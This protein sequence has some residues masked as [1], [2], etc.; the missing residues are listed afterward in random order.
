M[1]FVVDYLRLDFGAAR[2]TAYVWP[3]VT[4]GDAIRQSATA[5]T[6][7]LCVRSSRTK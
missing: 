1:V 2:S 4:I 6:A 7:T 5:D 3:R